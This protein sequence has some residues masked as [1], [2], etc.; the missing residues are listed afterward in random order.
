MPVG[1]A[2]LV[3]VLRQ[4]GIRV[5]GLNYP[6]Q[7]STSAG[8]DLRQWLGRRP[9]TRVVL[10]DLHW[11]EHSYGAISVAKA[12]PADMIAGTQAAYNVTVSNGGDT[13]ALSGEFVSEDQRLGDSGRADPAV[14]VVELVLGVA[15]DAGLTAVGL[16]HRVLRHLLDRHRSIG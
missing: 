8:F 16:D 14:E 13:P 3:N 5:V 1:V 10:I 9:G 4:N 15:D 7:R 6:L 11:Y 12:C 2:A